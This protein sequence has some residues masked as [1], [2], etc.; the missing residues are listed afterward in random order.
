M[1]NKLVIRAAHRED[2]D[3]ILIL[4]EE[5]AAYANLSEHF[6]ITKEKLMKLVFDDQKAQVILAELDGHPIGY[7]LY[8]DVFSSFIGEVAMYLEDL[9]ITPLF[10]RKGYGKELLNVIKDIGKQKGYYRIEWK[11]L[12]WNH[13][14]QDFYQRI[15]ATKEDKNITFLME[16]S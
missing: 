13:Q 8:Y 1:S 16:I 6:R 12:K 7:A 10:R 5:F 2:I 9:Y 3:T 11:C 14:A 15:G 4:M